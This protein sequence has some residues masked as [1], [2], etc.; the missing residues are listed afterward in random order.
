MKLRKQSRGVAKDDRQGLNERVRPTTTPGEKLIAYGAAIGGLLIV[1]GSLGYRFWWVP[2]HQAPVATTAA[3]TQQAANGGRPAGI[4]APQLSVPDNVYGQTD[5][6]TTPSNGQQPYGAGWNPNGPS[7][8]PGLITGNGQGNGQGNAQD[9]AA[10]QQQQQQQALAQQRAQQEQQIEARKLSGK[11]GDMPS[12]PPASGTPVRAAQGAPGAPSP[13]GVDA[14]KATKDF[15]ASLIPTVTPK[16]RAAYIPNPSLTVKK[17]TPIRC[18]LDTAMNSDQPSFPSC[19]VSRPVYSMDGNVILIDAGST[20]DGEVTKGPER[21]KKRQAALWGRLVMPDNTTIE[22][23]SPATD[24]LG[25]GG[26]TGSINNHY[27]E[28]YCGAFL[29]STFEDIEQVGVSL[30]GK[31]SGNGN[32]N[33][34]LPQNTM[35]TANSAT[36]EMLT[37][38][39]DIQP[40]FSKNQGDEITITV[41]RDLD[42]STVYHLAPVT[43]RNTDNP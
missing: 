27:C 26:M 7:N 1:F 15:A 39:R 37:Q 2:T 10:L 28:R 14:N 38:G 36:N 3:T 11:L 29:Y 35:S 6:G 42:F 25:A 19:V 31:S 40:T 20:V 30:A 18:T 17:G 13:V 4:S 33:I 21:G 34:V 16:T 23:D 24:T 5:D 41:G 43:A 32:T 22:L 12:S 8:T 9:A